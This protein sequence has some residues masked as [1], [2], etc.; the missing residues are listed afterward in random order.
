[1]TKAFIGFVV[2]IATLW[3]SSAVAQ[4][5]EPQPAAKIVVD[6]PLAEPL[7][8]GVV[9]SSTAPKI[10]RSSRCSARR[11]SMC[12][13]AS[14]ISMWRLMARRG[15]GPK[16]AA[17]P[18]LLLVYLRDRTRSRLRPSTQTI[19]PWI[20]ASSSNSS[21]PEEGRRNRGLCSEANL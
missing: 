16:P 21:S 15:S 14:G 13:P 8:R 1:M 3:T 10:C 5:A 20:E 11:L 17:G 4:T 6:A 7:S 18:S 9:S 12:R 19:T 2:A